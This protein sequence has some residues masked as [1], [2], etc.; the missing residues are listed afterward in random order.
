MKKLMLLIICVITGCSVPR[1]ANNSSVIIQRDT[2]IERYDTTLIQLEKEYIEVYRA[3]SSYLETKYSSSKAS[4]DSLG[5]LHH[6]IKNKDVE[7]PVKTIIKEK[8]SYRDSIQIKEIPVEVEKVIT[9]Y[10]KSFWLLLIW[11]V[12]SVLLLIGICYMK[13]KTAYFK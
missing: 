8:I 2:I 12:L 13:F 1:I 11:F 10:P 5:Y 6:S 9:V 3:D 4:I 7:I